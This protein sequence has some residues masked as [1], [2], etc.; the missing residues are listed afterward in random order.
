MAVTFS[1][2]AVARMVL[3]ML[4][5]RLPGGEYAIVFFTDVTPM[6]VHLMFIPRNV[7]DIVVEVMAVHSDQFVAVGHG[8]GGMESCVGSIEFKTSGSEC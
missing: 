3:V 6:H 1:T 5:Q 8:G 7:R 4:P 2:E